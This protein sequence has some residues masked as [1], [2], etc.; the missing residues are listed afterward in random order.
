V[1]SSIGEQQKGDA[2][3]DSAN[4]QA[5]QLERK[6]GL[7]RASS[8]RAAGEED[9]QGRLQQS[10]ALAVAASSGAGASDSG[11]MEHMAQLSA[12]TNYRKMVALY[13]GEE[14]ANQ[15]EEQAKA[16]RKGGAQAAQAGNIAATGTILSQGA[17][18]YGKYG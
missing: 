15:L 7:E 10:R 9:R 11:F 2:A 17:S 5:K 3:K 14:G 13:E 12:E 8:Q 4:I 16:T 18:L 6:A 1:V